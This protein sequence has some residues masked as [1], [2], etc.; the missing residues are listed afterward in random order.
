VTTTRKSKGY[1]FTITCGDQKPRR[2]AS[3][4]GAKV[5]MGRMMNNVAKGTT[6]EI[7]EAGVLVLVGE[8]YSLGWFVR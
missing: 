2:A 3:L 4:R 6:G 8:C 1:P 5:T 7:R